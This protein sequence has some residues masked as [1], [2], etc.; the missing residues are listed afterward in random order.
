ML[1]RPVATCVLGSVTLLVACS[2]PMV[3]SDREHAIA[4]AYLNKPLGTGFTLGGTFSLPRAPANR[5]WYA[6]WFT[7]AQKPITGVVDHGLFLGLA[8]EALIGTDQGVQRL[9]R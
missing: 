5:G 3:H 1:A 6:D 8:D 9:G 7:Y 4:I 2:A